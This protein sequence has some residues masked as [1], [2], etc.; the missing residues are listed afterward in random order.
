MK[1]LLINFYKN[2]NENFELY[3]SGILIINIVLMLTIQTILRYFFGYAITWT[4]EVLRI[5]FIWGV[6]FATGNSAKRDKHIRITVPLKILFRKK[7]RNLIL[8]IGDFI[9]FSYSIF[10]GI[11]G[12]KLVN[13][14]FEY[15]YMSPTLSVNMAFFYAIV[16]IIYF[17]LSIRVAQ[18][19]LFQIKNG[20]RRNEI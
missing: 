7:I 1:N 2:I 8:L 17:I 10:L 3:I 5:S 6:Y 13:S 18:N 12:V 14:M 20:K 4:E 15:P 19:I 9:F 16:P 11:E